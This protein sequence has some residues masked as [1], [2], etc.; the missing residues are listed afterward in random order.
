MNFARF[1][2][3][4]AA[5]A[6]MAALAQ[7]PA[8]SSARQAREAEILSV[9]KKAM[10]KLERG[11]VDG[12]L[13]HFTAA[14]KARH[15]PMFQSLGPRLPLVVQNLGTVRRVAAAEKSGE[16]ELMRDTPSGRQVFS[17][18]FLKGRDGAW[19]IDGM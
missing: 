1:I 9:Y 17:V 5:L 8:A 4:V 15:R 16:I 6:C 14:G 3:I 7:A 13:T 2:A 10:A 11:D 19:K 18:T 12:A